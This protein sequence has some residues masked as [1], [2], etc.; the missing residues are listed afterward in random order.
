MQ[1]WSIDDKIMM[2]I[3]YFSNCFLH[4]IGRNGQLYRNQ[5]QYVYQQTR[6]LHFI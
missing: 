1:V 5:S 4:I 2:I 6:Q 3:I